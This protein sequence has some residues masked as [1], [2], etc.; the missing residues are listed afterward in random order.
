MI[1]Y[2][3]VWSKACINNDGIHDYCINKYYINNYH[4]KKAFNKRALM[5]DLIKKAGQVKLLVMDVD[6]ILSNGQIIYDAN[7]IETKAFSVQDGLGV[8]SVARYGI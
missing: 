4:I 2:K 6:G 8:K 1:Y 7:L 3:P 5:Q